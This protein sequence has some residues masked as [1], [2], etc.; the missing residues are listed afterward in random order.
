M[1]VVDV[2]AT[3]HLVPTSL[4]HIAEPQRPLGVVVVRV[5]TDA[6]IT[7]FGMAPGNRLRRSIKELINTDLADQLKG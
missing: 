7:G 6:N 5:E 1:K 2:T 4:P 3:A